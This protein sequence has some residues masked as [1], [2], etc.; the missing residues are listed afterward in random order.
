M[1]K[2]KPSTATSPATDPANFLKARK[3]AQRVGVCS[4]TIHRWAA[5]GLISR[6]KVNSH[7]VLYDV[8]E[9]TAFVEGC[10]V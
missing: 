10:K 3:I 9:V 8:A 6:R 4:A 2:P 7:V 1:R 5:D